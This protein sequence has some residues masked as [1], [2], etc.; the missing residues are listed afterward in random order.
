MEQSDDHQ[1]E[2]EVTVE[3]LP[4]TVAEVVYL[5]A[6]SSPDNDR[7]S[8]D[9]N[10][11]G[12]A[13]NGSTNDEQLML[14]NESNTYVVF[15]PDNETPNE[16]VLALYALIFTKLYVLFLERI[17]HSRRIAEKLLHCK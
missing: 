10:Y 8:I 4:E 12:E 13:S 15:A 14:E 6:Q 16:V 1:D 9:K 11:K 17:Y 7:C 5:S 3:V 2:C